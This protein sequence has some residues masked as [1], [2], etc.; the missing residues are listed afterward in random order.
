[1]FLGPL[2]FIRL[3]ET[4]MF[5]CVSFH[6]MPSGTSVFWPVL[7][8]RGLLRALSR[9]HFLKMVWWLP[10]GKTCGCGLL[11]IPVLHLH[12]HLL[13]LCYQ[14]MYLLFYR[15]CGCAFSACDLWQASKSEM[16]SWSLSPLPQTGQADFLLGRWMVLGENRA[17]GKETTNPSVGAEG[18]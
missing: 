3:K 1:M 14:W 13:R 18:F 9:S 12:L 10:D 8:Y 11:H 6:K 2:L 15:C 7:C 5:F 16:Q 17:L 4:T